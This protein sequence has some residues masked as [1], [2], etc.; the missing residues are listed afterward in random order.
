MAEQE[1]GP[2]TGLIAWLVVMIAYYALAANLGPAGMAEFKN[3]MVGD[4]LEVWDYHFAPRVP[5]WTHPLILLAAVLVIWYFRWR[6]LIVISRM[7]CA[8]LAARFIV[9]AVVY[10][11]G[12]YPITMGWAYIAQGVLAFVWYVISAYWVD[13]RLRGRLYGLIERL[14]TD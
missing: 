6:V 4:Y 3:F 12:L 13:S 11:S 10:V 14:R 1:N 8:F 5:A 7:I 9:E 2:F